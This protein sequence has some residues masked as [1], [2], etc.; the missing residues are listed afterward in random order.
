MTFKKVFTFFTVFTL[1]L[2]V[3]TLVAIQFLAVLANAKDWFFL[4]LFMYVVNLSV[5]FFLHKYSFKRT[6]SFVNVFL[7]TSFGKMMIYIAILLLYV[8]LNPGS[9][10]PFI[11]LFLVYFMFFLIFE[12]SILLKFNRNLQL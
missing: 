8:Y 3:L 9:A 7:L 1:I 6:V 12:V 11:V 5:L 10:I 2:A 4:L